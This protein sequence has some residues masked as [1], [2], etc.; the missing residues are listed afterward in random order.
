MNIQ[1]SASESAEHIEAMNNALGGLTVLLC[2]MYPDGDLPDEIYDQV[3]AKLSATAIQIADLRLPF[4]SALDECVQPAKHRVWPVFL[5]EAVM[6]TQ[7]SRAGLNVDMNFHINGDVTKD[8]SNCDN[9][10]FSDAEL[11][12]QIHA[13]SVCHEYIQPFL[14]S[15]A[16]ILRRDLNIKGPLTIGMI[17]T[18]MDDVREDGGI[19]KNDPRD[20]FVKA[21]NTWDFEETFDN[22]E[23]GPAA[24]PPFYL[25]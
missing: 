8:L 4:C 25:H 13:L 5:P 18:V 6:M 2:A 22:D 20:W 24:S 1:Q 12:L 16:A 19:T 21:Y 15:C 10:H 7:G 9:K 3:P 17:E 23:T 14:D 11:R